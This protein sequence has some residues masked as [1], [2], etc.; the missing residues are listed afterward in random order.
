LPPGVVS[1]AGSEI[2]DH[3]ASLGVHLLPWQRWVVEAGTSERANGDP[4]AF[5]CTNIAPRQNGK[6]EILVALELAWLFLFGDELIVHSAQLFNTCTEHFLRMRNIIEGSP[7][8]SSKVRRIASANG[9]EAIILMSGQRLNFM[10]RSRHGARGFTGDKVV[11]DEAYDLSARMLGA[12]IPTLSTRQGAQVWYTS[13]APHIDSDVLHDLRRR[14]TTAATEDDPYFFAEWGNPADVATDDW[15]AVYSANPSAGVLIHDD[16]L[17]NEYRS[18]CAGGDPEKILEYRRERLG[19][20]ETNETAGVIPIDR[21]D[22]LADEKSMPTGKP[23]LAFDVSPERSWASIGAAGRR[24]D[25]LSHVE[26]VDRMS[27]TGWLVP[28]LV[29]LWAKHHVP[30]RFDPSS[31]AG[32]FASDLRSRGVELIEVTGRDMAQAC[33]AFADAVQNETVRHLG[34]PAIHN[35]LTGAGK[36]SMGDAWAWS[37]VSSS[38]DITPLVAVTLAHAGLPDPGGAAHVW[39]FTD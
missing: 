31:P 10:A 14:G 21:W 15:D 13:S 7:D 35:A 25:G 34:S 4:A 16:Y 24:A 30:L 20:P 33:G 12:M 23:C 38:V 39:A 32:S 37:R 9:K 2:V 8:L 36:R 11:F 18:F 28:R 29:E 22:A 26:V 27:G 5:E 19:I 3:A 6:N 17:R 1:S